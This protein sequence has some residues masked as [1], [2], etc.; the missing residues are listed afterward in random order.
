MKRIHYF[1]NI[2]TPLTKLKTK[3]TILPIKILSLSCLYIFYYKVLEREL[4]FKAYPAD[5]ASFSRIGF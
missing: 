2:F 1:V 5:K 4:I 3:K